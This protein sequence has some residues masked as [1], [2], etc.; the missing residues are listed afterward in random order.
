MHRTQPAASS[1]PAAT[2]SAA[3]TASAPGSLN[4][5]KKNSATIPTIRV[6]IPPAMDSRPGRRH[7]PGRVRRLHRLLHRVGTRLRA[8]LEVAPTSS[9]EGLATHHLGAPELLALARDLYDSQPRGASLITIG[10]GSIELGE[11]FSEPVLDAIPEACRLL[12]ETILNAS[13]IRITASSPPA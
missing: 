3:T 2:P 5:P 8:G 9:T 7:R 10:A 11:T 4:G 12:E 6:I 1:S 13:R